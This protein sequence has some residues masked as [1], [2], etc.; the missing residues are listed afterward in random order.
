R[1][2]QFQEPGTTT[3]TIAGTVLAVA[4]VGLLGSFIIQIRWFEGRYHGLVP[5][6]YLIAT[7]KG[8]DTG[9]YAAGRLAGRN[10]LWPRLSPH[11][12][13]EGAV[14]GLFSG[15]AAALIVWAIARFLLQ[16]P[17]LSLPAAVGFGV[18]VGSVAQ[19]GD[20]ME[21]M[22]K[23]DCARKDASDAVPG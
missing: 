11:K 19:L 12:T 13:A 6:V 18:I 20:L 9:A 10:K 15:V 7:A 8:A 22:I 1:S 4:Y 3:A 14:G 2:V 21:S 23:R 16:I 17:T 5:I